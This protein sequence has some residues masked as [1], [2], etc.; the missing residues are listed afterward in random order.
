MRS[1]ERHQGEEPTMS[2]SLRAGLVALVAG[3]ALLAPLSASA[4]TVVIKDRA[5]DVWA[6]TEDPET[7]DTE[8]SKAGSVANTDIENVKIAHSARKVKV[9]ARYADLRRNQ[10]FVIFGFGVRT[11]ESVRRDAYVFSFDRREDEF[12]VRRNGRL[13]KC[14]GMRAEVQW[15]QD[16]VEL[17]IPRSCL[18]KPRWI[19]VR[20]FAQS[21]PG[22]QLES[23]DEPFVAH[24]DAVGKTGWNPNTW[25][26]RVSRG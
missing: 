18:S 1:V 24:I 25:S 5:G 15:P 20:A 12:L 6:M 22:E 9:W 17:D 11:N 10:D 16:E 8:L 26:Q 13:L 3:A 14:R 23:A 2:L 19:Q 7:W 21:M 4:E